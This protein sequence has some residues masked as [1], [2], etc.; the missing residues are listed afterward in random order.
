MFDARSLKDIKETLEQWARMHAHDFAKE[1]KNLFTCRSG[2]PVKRCYTPLDLAEKGFD[3]LSDV[4]L[5]GDFPFVTGIT[6]TMYRSRLWETKSYSGRATAEECNELWKSLVPG[7]LERI[8][9]ALDLPTQLG[10]DP[11][12]PMAEGEVGRVG[13][14]MTSLRDWEIALNGIDVGKVTVGI[15]SNALAAVALAS[16]IAIA[17]QQGIELRQLRGACQND[18]LKEYTVRGNYIFPLGPS[19]RLAVD[20]ICHCAK[21]I[22]KYEPINVSVTHYAHRGA[23]PVHAAAFGLANAFTYLQAVKDRGLD[24][25]QVA[26]HIVFLGNCEHTDFFQ[27]IAKHRAMRKIYARTLKERLG[28]KDPESMICRV[29]SSNGGLSLQKEQ[30]LNNIARNAIAGL[31]AA[32]SGCLAVNL[33]A[34]DEHFGTPTKEAILTS[35]RTQQIIAYETGVTDTVDPLAGSYFI[36]S[37][38]LEF[39]G[40]ILEEIEAID[41]R[42]GV[43]HCI[44][45]GYFQR[46]LAE[47]GYNWQKAV[48]S[49]DMVWVGVNKFATPDEESR[50][51]R[52][53]RADPKAEEQ[54]IAAVREL[55]R[56]RDN[57]R[58]RKALSDL[59]SMALTE[60][61]PEN[62]LMPP[63]IEAVK[64]YCTVGEIA[65]VLRE[66][67]G[68]HTEARLM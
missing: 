8:S 36:E 11:D 61:R 16:H 20:T 45:D 55:R 19:L 46:I 49:G 57:V 44:E 43:L 52:I 17:E 10:L 32:L 27:E 68:E 47:D 62:D 56:S 40:R 54:R 38:T 9:I 25:D 60:A 48:E 50:P 51:M 42:G 18:I 23:T 6:P 7:G 21:Y 3:Y 13:L 30:Y 58:V 63:I 39:E 66:V 28:A 67:W 59:K 5:P 22:P 15:V 1:R 31:A 2:I 34:Y 33:R 24:I 41:R 12:H 37:L 35:L 4:G 65:D 64:A 14:S 26:P 29:L 53:Y